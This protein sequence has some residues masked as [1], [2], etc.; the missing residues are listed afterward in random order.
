MNCRTNAQWARIHEINF[1][2]IASL[3]KDNT[4]VY[5]VYAIFSS[6]IN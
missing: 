5:N 3:Q 1:D 2:I 6:E 4:L